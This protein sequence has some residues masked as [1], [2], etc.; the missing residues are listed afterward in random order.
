MGNTS[1]AQSQN[2]KD[3]TQS[4]YLDGLSDDLAFFTTEVVLG[5]IEDR[6]LATTGAISKREALSVRGGGQN[7]SQ[8]C[9]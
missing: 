8:T 7:I 6:H 2:D 5:N 1:N 4:S 9:H 3:C